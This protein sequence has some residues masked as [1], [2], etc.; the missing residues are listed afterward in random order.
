MLVTPPSFRKTGASETKLVIP[1]DYLCRAI[2]SYVNVIMEERY[3]E[4]QRWAVLEGRVM[5]ILRYSGRCRGGLTAQLISPCTC[6]PSAT[7]GSVFQAKVSP[8]GLSPGRLPWVFPPEHRPQSLR[9]F[10]LAHKPGLSTR[11]RAL[12]PSILQRSY[13]PF[14]ERQFQI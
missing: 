4:H 11:V 5:L 1:V 13:S 7:V 9:T 10:P 3:S 14:L 8:T 6:P 12:L 2:N